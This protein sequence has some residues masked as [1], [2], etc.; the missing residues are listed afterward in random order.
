VTPEELLAEAVQRGI[1]LYLDGQT[2]RYRGPKTALADLKP[3]LASYKHGLLP[4]LRTE[5][6]RAATDEALTLLQRLKTFTL[7][8]GRMPAAREIAERWSARLVR[9]ENG[10]PVDEADDPASSLA[11]LRGIERELTA[12]GGV[13]DPALAEAVAVV[14]G[15]FPGSQLV[16]IRRKEPMQ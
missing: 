16:E 7:P 1:E 12:L 5:R 13:P 11:V 3:Q 15:A 2:I 14:E 6:D 9:W 8:A 4:L 10:E